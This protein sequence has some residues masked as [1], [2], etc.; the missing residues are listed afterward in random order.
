MTTIE[1]KSSIKLGVVPTH[2]QFVDG[3]VPND[4]GN[5]PRN[6]AGE[7]KVVS[8]MKALIELTRAK[9]DCV[10]ISLFPGVND[11]DFDEMVSGLRN[12]GL[13]VHFILMVGGAGDPMDPADESA[14]VDCLV[15][16]LQ[17]ADKFGIKT[18]S[19]T[20]IEQWM[21]P[22]A[23]RKE[24]AEF[25]AAIEQ[26]V[27]VHLKACEQ[28]GIASTSIDS[29]H[30]E[31]LRDVEFQTFT[32]LGR[33]WQFVQRA[34]S[35]FGSPFFKV[36]V[37]AAHC[38]DSQLSL[39]QNVALIEEI[40]AND[41]LSTFHASAKTTRGCLS[42]D[43]GWI[44]SL[45]AACAKTGKLEYVFGEMFHHDDVALEPLRSAVLGHGFDTTDGRSYDETLADGLND[46]VRRLNNL[47]GRGIGGLR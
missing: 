9:L 47:A 23:K 31:F 15:P 38:G 13:E 3:L 28:A 30:I 29:W 17:A 12:L 24:G 25:E 18:V 32:D 11:S 41:G 45:L 40:G 8:R 43:D 35:A 7:I 4:Q 42:T 6:E 22:G 5:M 36:L 14:V 27:A 44:G 21:T 19:S 26:N 16:C 10:Q 34:N 46:L 1:S 20:S 37:D 2:I 33:A 39:D